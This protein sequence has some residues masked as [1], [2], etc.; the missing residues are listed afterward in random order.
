MPR[1]DPS[2]RRGQRLPAEPF[3]RLRQALHLALCDEYAAHDFYAAVVEAF[4]PR[5]PFARIVQ[6]ETRHIRALTGLYRRLGIPLPRDPYAARTR[7]DPDWRSNCARAVAGEIANV[8]LYDRLLAQIAEPEARQVFQH[9]RAASLRHHLPAFRR[10]LA[11]AEAGERYHAARGIPPAQAYVRHGP[12][13]EL[14][15][16]TLSRLGARGGALGVLGP[17]LGRSHPAML[18]GMALGGA[19]IY[20]LRH[21]SA[22][23]SQEH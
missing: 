16:K 15:E 3:A 7:V 14:A 13:A 4:G 21:R 12:L 19:G 18:A 2:L 6:A 1:P 20:L 9:L 11:Q 22:A 5:L 10:A 8:R 23:P 17:L